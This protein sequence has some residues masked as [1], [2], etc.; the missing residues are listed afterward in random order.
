MNRTNSI[1]C[2]TS[3]REGS[4]LIDGANGS[5]ALRHGRK[6]SGSRRWPIELN[7]RSGTRG[8]IE[9]IG[10]DCGKKE[11]HEETES[12]KTHRGGEERGRETL[13][14]QTSEDG[15]VL[16]Q[17]HA[18]L[19]RPGLASVGGIQRPFKKRIDTR[20]RGRVMK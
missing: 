20:Q 5:S 18:R 9:W 2:R 15:R 16:Y 7:E 1:R 10:T 8:E 17:T 11:R 4:G 12:T 6:E 19:K 14:S 13:C 3:Y